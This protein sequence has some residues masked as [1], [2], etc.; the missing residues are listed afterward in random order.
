LLSK[1]KYIIKRDLFIQ[2]RA[3]NLS[4]NF[5]TDFT[6]DTT[7]TL[8]YVSGSTLI[9][10][11]DYIYDDHVKNVEQSIEQMKPGDVILVKIDLIDEFFTKIFI[12]LTKPFILI[13]HQGD[14]S[15]DIKHAKYLNDSKLLVWFG[16]NPG[17][18]HRKHI[19]IPIGIENSFYFPD[20]IEYQRN[21]TS[22][23]TSRQLIPWKERKYLLYLNYNPNTNSK[24]RMNLAKMFRLFESVLIITEKVDY[25]TYMSHIENSKY[26]ICPQGNGL[27]THRVYEAILMGSIPIVEHSLLDDFYLKSTSLI[28]NSYADI[29]IEK[30][31]T[32][33]QRFIRNMNFSKD[34]LYMDYWLNQMKKYKSDLDVKKLMKLPYEI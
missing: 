1:H 33:H 23:R 11:S 28:V 24:K 15:T 5:R 16:Q 31:Y 12:K 14:Y 29:N 19:P 17:F 13:T 10:Y 32:Y 27:D 7:A 18:K 25:P 2:K 6:V 8:P 34:V 21:L 4:K 22:L 30:L 9:L 26:V 20:K 3:I